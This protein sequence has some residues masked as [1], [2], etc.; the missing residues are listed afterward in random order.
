M[1]TLAR[2]SFRHRW[3]VLAV[4]LLGVVVLSIGSKIAGSHYQDNTALPGTQS[5]RALHML[6]AASPGGGGDVDRIVFGVGSGSVTEPAVQARVAPMLNTVRTLPHVTAVD[7]PFIPA[8]ARQVSTDKRT[9]FALVEFDQQ[10]QD[11]SGSTVKRVMSTARAVAGPGLQ[12]ELGG[13]A[14]SNQTKPSLGGVYFGIVAA[15]VVLFLA[16]GSLVAMALPLATAVVSLGAG[17]GLIGLLSKAI[18]M[19]TFTTQLASLIALGVGVDYAMFIVSR[20]RQR[21]LAGADPEDATVTAVNTSGRAVL[22]AGITVC[23]AILGMF[24]LGISIFYGVAVATGLAVVITVLAALTL[25][26]ALLGFFGKRVL[27]RRHRRRIGASPAVSDADPPRWTHWAGRLQRRPARHAV[28]GVAVIAVLAVPFFSL[29]LGFSDAGNDPTGA[30][31]RKAY[32][33][34]A[35]GFGPGFNGP[36]QLVAPATSPDASAAFA[37]VLGDAAQDR[38]V[39]A[40]TP[41]SVLG[42]GARRVLTA[43]L[44]PKTAP[45]ASAT[46]ALLHRLRDRSANTDRDVAIGGVTALNADL[47]HKIAGRLPLFIGLVIALSFLLLMAVFRSLLVPLLAAV[48]NVLSVAAAFGITTAVFEWGWLAKPLGVHT[49]P[50]EPYIPVIVFAILFGLSMDYEVFLVARIHEAWQHTKDNAT[51]VAAGVTRTGRTIT[52]A[53]AIMIAV[54]AS[55][56]LGDTRVVKLFGLGLAAAV[57]VDALIVR[58]LVL[59]AIMFLLGRANWTIPARLARVLPRLAVEPP[60]PSRVSTRLPAPATEPA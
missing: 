16:F 9:A 56:T 28:A 48:M 22:F 36:F 18:P 44:Y 20:Y 25:Q 29:R 21:L 10:A 40:V 24:A 60:E 6:Q 31:T 1:Q 59:P 58:T 47:S 53:A 54:F 32:D 50:I 33:M 42:S 15:A 27:A 57:L 34:L 46:T 23:I 17:L 26:P 30:T 5:S 38:G 12:V 3:L 41:P 45:Q 14:I 55:F 8:G 11:L 13:Q 37:T 39:A 2:W 19:A 35:A 52:A 51:A 49:A 43:Q 4:W 7:S